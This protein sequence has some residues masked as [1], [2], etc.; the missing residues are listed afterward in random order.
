MKP[1]GMASAFGG[2]LGIMDIY[3]AQKVFGRG[4][5]FDRIDIGAGEGRATV[6]DGAC[7]NCARCSGRAS[8]WSRPG[9]GRAV[10]RP[11]RASIRWR[12]TFTS[13]FALFIGMFIIYNTFA[14]AVTQRRPEIGILRALGAT[15]RQIRTLFLWR[16]WSPGARVRR[17]AVVRNPAGARHGRLYRRHADGSL[18]SR[19]ERPAIWC[20]SRGCLAWPWSIGVGDQLDRGRDSGAQRGGRRSREG[21]AEGRIPGAVGEGESRSGAALGI[22]AR[23]RGALACLPL[24]ALTR[25]IFYAGYVLSGDGGA[26][27]SPG[28]AFWLARV[29]GRRWRGCGRSRGAGGGQPDSSAAAHIRHR[30]RADAVAGAGDRAGRARAGELTIRSASGCGSRSIRTCS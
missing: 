22:G 3:A 7:G 4:R 8:R 19:A 5:R 24:Q 20:S 9:R 17:W 13:L 6:R 1:G 12:A 2:D 27:A 23:R 29:C 30:R 25:V 16:A 11:A 14:I 15:R 26:A 18:R 21:A 28:L 10:R